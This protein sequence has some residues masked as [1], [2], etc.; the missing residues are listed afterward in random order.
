MDSSQK[1]IDQAFEETLRKR[2]EDFQAPDRDDL[3]A[4]IFK[5][6][7]NQRDMRWLVAAGLLFFLIS[8]ILVGYFFQSSE[9]GKVAT[10]AKVLPLKVSPADKSDTAKKSNLDVEQ[11]PIFGKKAKEKALAVSDLT[12][13]FSGSTE[14]EKIKNLA[15]TKRVQQGSASSSTWE[16]DKSN[17]D[18]AA[19]KPGSMV[20]RR[21]STGNAEKQNQQMHVEL[22][23]GQSFHFKKYGLPFISFPHVAEV[24][25][26]SSVQKSSQLVPL[27]GVTALQYF[28]LINLHSDTEKPFQNVGFAPLFSARSTGYKAS[29]G[30]AKGAV[31]LLFNYGYQRSWNYYELGTNQVE[32]GP[33]K[34]DQYVLR[35]R[36]TPY[37]IDE[38]LH[39]LGVS[40][41]APLPLRHTPLKHFETLVGVEYTRLLPGHSSLFWVNISSTKNFRLGK[42]IDVAVGPFAEYSIKPRT[43][44]EGRWQSHPYRVGL[45]AELKIFKASTKD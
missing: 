33:V 37:E 39:M 45:T 21:D 8:A 16:N 12:S 43:L 41:R 32:V 42:K 3:A 35:R 36:G 38:K 30:L 7:G 6:I 34:G 17:A 9:P 15:K 5:S 13:N 11:K 20:L 22:L 4:P 26:E 10:P 2:F 24:Q 29:V 1:K 25:A 19:W 31:H 27:F 18:G 44:L 40:L 23:S 14:G 28:Q